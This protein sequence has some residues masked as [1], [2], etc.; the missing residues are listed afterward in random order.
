[1]TEMTDK[2][3]QK[4][5]KP[6]IELTYTDYYNLATHILD[7]KSL[8]QHYYD[9]ST[10]YRY[11]RLKVCP[12]CGNF[13]TRQSHQCSNA[14]TQKYKIEVFPHLGRAAS[15]TWCNLG[16]PIY[17]NYKHNRIQ[18]SDP[19]CHCHYPLLKTS[20]GISHCIICGTYYRSFRNP[21]VC[22]VSCAHQFNHLTKFQITQRYEHIQQTLTNAYNEL[23]YTA[24]LSKDAP[25][26]TTFISTYPVTITPKQFIE[27]LPL[28]NSDN[29][30]EPH[31]KHH[32]NN[33]LIIQ[34]IILFKENSIF[35]I[36]KSKTYMQQQKPNHEDPI[37]LPLI[38]RILQQQPKNHQSKPIPGNI[39]Y[40]FRIATTKTINNGNPYVHNPYYGTAIA[41]NI[42]YATPPI[43]LIRNK[44]PQLTSNFKPIYRHTYIINDPNDLN[45]LLSTVQKIYGQPIIPTQTNSKPYIPHPQYKPYLPRQLIKFNPDKNQ[46]TLTDL[47]G[48]I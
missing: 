4:Q 22:S 42:L 45:N 40:A 14:C 39:N 19:N 41:W 33:N 31:I 43:G 27:R 30:L 44:L 15:I 8:F 48:D 46:F 6:Q 12:T 35:N 28:L 24:M 37:W 3:L 2:Q 26:N 9:Y 36:A 32:T 11:K 17:D 13:H 23:T 21:L 18:C 34:Q 25:P 47:N 20:S 5:K 16:S 7:I 29:L 1:M 38:S 10:E